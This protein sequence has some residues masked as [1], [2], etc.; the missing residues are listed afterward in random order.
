MVQS[1]SILCVLAF[2]AAIEPAPP[3]ES[4]TAP[5]GRSPK[6]A[7]KPQPGVKKIDP[8]KSAVYVS[9]PWKYDLAVRSPGTRSEARRGRLSF[10]GKELL[11][12]E[13]NDYYETPWGPIYW[14]GNP[15]SRWGDHLW[16]PYPSRQSPDT[17]GKQLPAPAQGAQ[18]MVLTKADSGRT[19]S[20]AVGA[21]FQVQL[22]GNPTTGYQWVAAKLVGDAVKPLGPPAYE[23]R[24]HAEGMVGV[25]GTYTFRFHAVK[26]GEADITLH[27]LRSWEKGKTPAETFQVK[28]EI[29]QVA[30]EVRP[31][32]VVP[33]PKE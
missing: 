7:E 5:L 6:A 28:V 14:V 17:K 30:P 24:P 32:T 29:K 8:D 27:Y 22:A 3:T 31:S 21:T 19:V 12:A 26:P 11:A 20:V 15:R 18:G 33:E 9:D 2:G 16:M 13:V 23:T 4:P 1:I 25:G 10:A